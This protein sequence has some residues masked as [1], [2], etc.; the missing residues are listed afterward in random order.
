MV[1][2]K[3]RAYLRDIARA[4]RLIEEFIGGKTYAAYVWLRS[5]CAEMPYGAMRG[6]R[7]PGRSRRMPLGCVVFFPGAAVRPDVTDSFTVMNDTV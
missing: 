4:C 3:A 7:G 6:S 1:P 5:A 2:E